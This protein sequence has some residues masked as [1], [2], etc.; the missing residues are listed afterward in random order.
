MGSAYP[1]TPEEILALSA[2]I[3][4]VRANETLASHLWPYLNEAGLTETQ[5]GVLEVLHHLG[6]LCQRSLAE[7]LLKSGGNITLVIDNLEKRDLVC[8]TRN[9]QDRRYITVSLTEQGQALIAEIFPQHVQRL[10]A[11]M[12]VLSPEEQAQLRLLCRKL[13]RQLGDGA[14]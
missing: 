8:R 2:Y 7:K 13:G 5:F 10:C 6:P 14:A 4:L 9:P 1:G 3:T 12:A 11:F